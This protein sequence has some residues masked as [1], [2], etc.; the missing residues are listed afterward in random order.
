M[1]NIYLFFNIF[2]KNLDIIINFCN[3][4]INDIL[5]L[6][7]KTSLFRLVYQKFSLNKFLVFSPKIHRSL[8]L[9]KIELHILIWGEF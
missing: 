3:N 4:Q 2:K 8:C 1:K 9:R 6:R 7:V 5:G